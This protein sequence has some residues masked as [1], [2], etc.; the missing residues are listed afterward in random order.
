[1]Y[2]CTICVIHQA[3]EKRAI[4]NKKLIV[5]LKLKEIILSKTMKKAF[6]LNFGS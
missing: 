3:F 4:W 1:M 5:T 6:A 2:I